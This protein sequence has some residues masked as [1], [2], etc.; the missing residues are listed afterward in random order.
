MSKTLFRS[1][2]MPNLLPGISSS[3]VYFWILQ[4]FQVLHIFTVEIEW[5][6]SR[7]NLG[8]IFAIYHG[9]GLKT[10]TTE[11][12]IARKI[13]FK[14]PEPVQNSK[15]NFQYLICTQYCLKKCKSFK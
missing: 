3:K 4:K 7:Q 11:F 12:K 14:F 2:T 15:E 5:V 9:L 13:I 10:F 8:S 1:D 6:F